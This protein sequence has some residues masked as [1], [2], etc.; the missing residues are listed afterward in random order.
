MGS[1]V[2][3]FTVEEANDLVPELEALVDRAR[4]AVEAFNFASGQVQDLRRMHGRDVEDEDHPEHGDFTRFAEEAR[5]H[6]REVDEVRDAFRELGVE[7]KDPILGLVDMPAKHGE[8]VVYLCW[9]QGEPEVE[10]WHPRDEGF[11]GR[12]P[13]DELR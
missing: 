3:I 7:L 10:A 4:E 2:R 5:A 8:Q 6:R 11:Q 13:V 12:R 1:D 9:K